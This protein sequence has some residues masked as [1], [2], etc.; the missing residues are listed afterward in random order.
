MARFPV[1]E[2]GDGLEGLNDVPVAPVAA[3]RGVRPA[4]FPV[5]SPE[6][7]AAA[8]GRSL[9]VLKTEQ[10]ANPADPALEREIQRT[11]KLAGTPADK[12]APTWNEVLKMPEMQGLEHE[13]LEEARNQ[14]FLEVV[15]P[16][17]PTPDLKAAREAFDRDTAPSAINRALRSLDEA[18]RSPAD[19]ARRGIQA[20]DV[21]LTRERP[22]TPPPEMKPLDRPFMERVQGYMKQGLDSA[23]ADARV[24]RDIEAGKDDSQPVT[25]K[26]G[27]AGK[28]ARE[29]ERGFLGMKNSVDG[30]VM[31]ELAEVLE[32][33]RRD[34]TP[35][36]LAAD[37]DYAD[38]VQAFQRRADAMVQRKR[39][40]DALPRTSAVRKMFE[41]EGLEGVEN[42]VKGFRDD[43][44]GATAAIVG[45]SVP[46]TLSVIAAAVLARLGGTGAAGAV[47]AGGTASALNEFG[48]DYQ[49]LREEGQGHEEAWNRAAIKSGVVGLFD[50]ASLASGGKALGEI[51]EKV[52]KAGVLK[53]GA[54]Q[55]VK[56]SGKQAAL[57]AGGEV[58]GEALSGREPQP[59]AVMAEAAGELI[60]GVGEAVPAARR[61]GEK[62][63]PAAEPVKTEEPVKA[64]DVLGAKP[65]DASVLG[66][67]GD[68]DLFSQP[69]QPAADATGG[70]AKEAEKPATAPAFVKGAETDF[71]TER[72]AKLKGQYAVIDASE[73]VTSHDDALRDNPAYPKELQPRDRK[74]D[75]SEM[76]IAKIAQNL[77]P[78]FLGES[79]Q[80]SQGAP[81]VGDD[82]V[83]ESGNARMIAL[84]RAYAADDAPGYR[85]WLK[86][87]AWKFGLKTDEIAG[88]KQ[89]VLVRLRTTDVNRAEF[90]RQANESSVAAMSPLEQA[91][92]DA[93]RIKHLDDLVT[94]EDGELST[95]ENRAFVR[96]FVGMLPVT[97][98]A[99]LVT[100][101]GQLSQS[102]LARVRN[103]ILSRAYGGGPV[104]QRLVESPDENIRAI[105]GGLVRA[106]PRVAKA[107]EA[108]KEG[109][110]HDLDITADLVKAVDWI[111]QLRTRGTPVETWLSQ[112][113]FFEPEA[114]PEFKELM[115]WLDQNGRGR[116]AKRVGEFIEAYLEAVQAAGS[117]AQ[118]TMFA[119]AVPSKGAIIEQAKKGIRGEEPQAGAERAAETR[120]DQRRSEAPGAEGTGRAAPQGESKPRDP[121]RAEGG[122]EKAPVAK[123]RP[124]ARGIKAEPAK[125]PIRQPVEAAKTEKRQPEAAP[126]SDEE[127]AK[128]DLKAALG[129]LGDILGKGTR[130][131]I[132]PEQEQKLLP[133]MTRLFDAAFRLGHIKFKQAARF[134]RD[135][136]RKALGK[137]VEDLAT[138]KRLKGAYIAMSD[139][140]DGADSEADVVAFTSIEELL[141]AS[142]AG[143]TAGSPKVRAD[144]LVADAKSVSDLLASHP[145]VEKSLG[146][147]NVDARRVMVDG[148]LRILED[149]K[150]FEAVVPLLPVNV[151][152]D[153]TGKK[154]TAEVLLGDKAVLVD[155]LAVAANGSVAIRAFDSLLTTVRRAEDSL[156]DVGERPS[157]QRAADGTGDGVRP[158]GQSDGD[159]SRRAVPAGSLPGIAGVREQGAAADGAVRHEVHDTRPAGKRKKSE[160]RRAS[161]AKADRLAAVR[162]HFT[163]GNI[164][165]SGYWR[166]HDRVLAFEEFE[167]AGW[168]VQVEKVKK[169][170]DKWVATGKPRW[171]STAP[172][173]RDKVVE[174]APAKAEPSPVDE[175][176]HEAASSPLNDKSEPSR[177]QIEANNAELGH[178]RV[179]GMDVSIENPVGSV[180]EDKKNTPPRWRV[181]MKDHYGYI[182]GTVAYDATE[183]R[184]QGVDIFLKPGTPE[185]WDGTVFVVNQNKG[186]GHF[187]EH[188]AM[189]G[190]DSLEEA[191]EAYLR[192]YDDRAL[193][194]KR[195]RSVVPAEMDAFKAWVYDKTEKG[196][197]GGAFEPA[198]PDRLEAESE[199]VDDAAGAGDNLEQ[200]RAPLPDEVGQG[201]L[202]DEPGGA[203]QGAGRAGA[204]IGEARD[205][206]TGDSGVP[207]DG[208]APRGE[209]GDQQ[210]HRPDGEYGAAEGAAGTDDGE[211]GG[212]AVG[213][214]VESEPAGSQ[215]AEEAADTA[216][217]LEVKRQK[218]RGAQNLAVEPGH[219]ANITRSLP[220]LLEGQQDD[221]KFAEDR[222]AKP[223]GHGVLFTNGTGTGKTF[224]GLGVVKRFERQGK[225]NILI[226]APTD[227]VLNAWVE[228]GKELLLD[229]NLLPD[230]QSAGDGIVATT[231]ANFGENDALALRDW[232]LIVGDEAHYLSSN[233]D[234][235]E[236]N[237]LRKLRALTKHARGFFPWFSSVERDVHNAIDAAR[238]A[239]D[240]PAE[241][242]ALEAYTAA[243]KKRQAEWDAKPRK[244]KLLALSATP[245]AYVK[246]VDWAEGYLFEYG[247][248]P[249]GRGYNTP[250]AQGAFFVQHFGFRMRTGKL[251]Q[252][253]AEVDTGLLEI[254]FN[255]WLKKQG[256]LSSRLL[257]VDKDY[258][259]SFVLVDAGIGRVIDEGMNW[260][261]EAEGGRFRPLYD[262]ARKRFKYLDRAFLLEA[263]KARAAVERAQQHLDLGRKVVVFHDYNKGGGFHPFHFA[264]G[265]ADQE[266]TIR[267][268]PEV[269]TAKRN[270][271]VAE[272]K[273]KR[274]DLAESNFAALNPP[275]VAF[276]K[277]FP[278]ALF[279]N[280]RMS[281]KE[282]R[283]ARDAFQR[284]DSGKNLI[285]VQS[286]AG[287]EGV[288]LHDVT[289]KHQR[290]LINL[291]LPV[292]PTAAIQIEGRTYR[293]G[294]Q[295]DAIFEYLNTGTSF[296]RYT[297]ASR[298]SERASTAE[299]L[300]LGAEARALKEA[301]IE[302][303]EEASTGPATAD[304]G[305]GGKER[306]RA[307][308]RLVSEF[309]KAKTYYWANQKKT[310]R[311]KAAEGVDYFATP[312]PLA[313]KMV[314]WA[315]IRPGDELLEPSAGHGAIARFFPK[316][317]KAKM[318]EPSAEL[319]TRAML[320]SGAELVQSR[321]EDF[322]IVNKADV[323]VMNPPFGQGGKTAID[324]LVKAMGHVRDGGRIVALLPRGTMAD[325]RLEQ[326]LHP[327]GEEERKESPARDFYTAADIELPSV[328]FER[329]G[330]SVRGHV[331][332]LDRV[333]DPEKAANM[334]SRDYSDAESIK[335]FFDRIENGS[336]P[337]RPA[338][339]E[340]A[341]MAST[342]AASGAAAASVEAGDWKL[343]E[344]K[345]EKGNVWQVAVPKEHLGDSWK[346]VLATAK[347]SDGWY[348]R[349]WRGFAFKTI[350][351][352]QAFIDKV[353]PKPK[354]KRE[355]RARRVVAPGMDAGAVQRIAAP[356]IGTVRGVELKIVSSPSEIPFEAPDDTQGVYWDGKLWLV[357]GELRTPQEVQWV[358]AH[359]L[360]HFGWQTKYGNRLGRVLRDLGKLN[361]QLAVEAKRLRDKFPEYDDV[362][363]LEEAVAD[364]MARG[365][366]SNLKGWDRFVAMVKI[367]L[368]EHGFT[369][370]FIDSL[371]DDE[372][373]LMVERV[374]KAMREGD[375]GRDI[376]QLSPAYHTAWHGSPHDFDEFDLEAVDS[377]EG[378]QS[379]GW[380]LY[381]T[382][383]KEVAEWYRGK[384]SSNSLEALSFS[385]DGRTIKGEALI[386][387]YF[388]PGRVVNG[389]SNKDKVI[390]FRPSTPE[391]GWAVRVVSVS[392]ASYV[393]GGDGKP[394]IGTEYKPIPYER[395]RWH[396]TWPGTDE[397]RKALTAEGWHERRG[398]LYKVDLAPKEDEY[399]DWNKPLKEQGASVQRAA[400][401][402]LG[403]WFTEK[404][405]PDRDDRV[406]MGS[407]FDDLNGSQI[408]MALSTSL[409]GQKEGFPDG[410]TGPD[411]EAASKALLAAGI[412]GIKYRGD[413][414]GVTN[415][416]IFDQKKIK[417]AAKFSRRGQADLNRPAAPAGV[418]PAAGRRESLLTTATRVPVQLLGIDKLTSWAYDTIIEKVGGI[419]PEK[420]KAGTVA[421]YGIPEAVIDRRE[422]MEAH[423]RTELRQ[424]QTV[425]D[426]LATLTR[427]E[428]RVAYAWMNDRDGDAL[429]AELP[430]E[431]Q[432][433]L[434]EVKVWI[435]ALSVEAVRLDQLS[436]ESY[437][438]NRMAYLHRS[439]R[440]YELDQTKQEQTARARSLKIRGDQYKG[441]GMV[442]DVDMKQV[443]NIAPD[444]W[445]RKLKEGAADKG[446]KGQKFIRFE[447]RENRGEGVATVPGVEASD[448]LGRL[449]D[450]VY[451][452][453]SEPVPARFGAWRRDA[454]EWEA[455]D[456]K[457]GKLIVWRDYTP[458]ERVKMGEIDEVRFAVAKTLQQMI[459]DVE[460][461]KFLEYLANTQGMPE[462]KLPRGSKVVEASESL[463]RSFGVDEWVQV[464]EGKVPGTAVKKYGKLAGLYIPGPIWNDV[465]QV[466]SPRFKPLGEAFDVAMRAW[467]ISKTALS[468]AVH[469][470]NIMA[471]VVMADWHDVLA[472][473]LVRA[474]AVLVRPDTPE[475]KKLLAAFEDNGG[476]QGMYTLSELQ[477]EQLSPLLEQ[478]E[479]EAQNAG[480]EGIINAGAVLQA[481]LSGQV[482]YAVAAAAGS[483]AA[484]LGK[485]AAEA[486]I[487][488][489]QAEDTVFRMAAFLKA[490]AE[491]KS[492]IEAGK[493]ARRSFLD[494]RINAP[495]IQ[496]LRSTIFPFIAF[497]YRALP[498]FLETMARK[499]W[500]MLK[501]WGVLAGLNAIGYAMSGGDEDKER[502][503]LPDEK[504]GGI[505][506]TVPK[507]IRMPWNDRDGNP[508]FL[509]IRRFVPVGDVFDLGQTHA[510]LPWSPVTVP[511]GPLAVVAE[512]LFN[513]SQFT[514]REI[515]KETDTALEAAGKILD[516]LYKAVA[517]NLPMLPGTYSF[518][519]IY[520]SAR[521]RTDVFG[522]EQ[523]TPAAVAS[524][525]GVKLG[526]YPA[527]VAKRNIKLERDMQVREIGANINALKR[528]RM[529]K[530]I[531]REEFERKREEQAEKRRQIDDEARDRLR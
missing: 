352:R 2:L 163:P 210:V 146:A 105:A 399:L 194:E 127:K 251:T 72:G 103:A 28:F 121:A 437:E 408:Y 11:A 434:R 514:G 154:G 169:D 157:N 106:A 415:Y 280:G 257:D 315:N 379:F 360:G 331:I 286:D 8:A 73:L 71:A 216:K 29:L 516:H 354:F 224:T 497:T 21:A 433:A 237:A 387:E 238:A 282:R 473:D 63:A 149:R 137:D 252:P 243:L 368:I 83:V 364:R 76:Q 365:E 455:R 388:K 144:S 235:V 385:K 142:H 226:V 470:N 502:K 414:S 18:V 195:V 20:I 339:P 302:A 159:A 249:E 300:A 320:A 363:S 522:R 296:E 310:S 253:E 458:E 48:N 449:L 221:V 134:V 91:K 528:E 4:G 39:Q 389:Y 527:D 259:R 95:A 223:D 92:S 84:R 265:A 450:L 234:G 293:I 49:A 421:D 104:L 168:Q 309:E 182:R 12:K 489:Y 22:A 431:S 128:A 486:M 330:T 313:F 42:F 477:R 519:S 432:A 277:A 246:S 479:R 520:D 183:K 425:L 25:V 467:K 50:A 351:A 336:V 483:K 78:E 202:F 505:W 228:S 463:W 66:G 122:D 140:K 374:A 391:R 211:R 316:L 269:V 9:S 324:H 487:D 328:T 56:E 429:L 186:N 44:A 448:Q 184:W 371:T 174:R 274:A 54:K 199:A 506:G 117:P 7:A 141:G 494:Y 130:L 152:N 307:T 338:K 531:S 13:Q 192:N 266:V 484:Q 511:G 123:K 264:E 96:R 218:Q 115:R 222:F 454:G 292:K 376:V 245:F 475:H 396:A 347:A 294:Q 384:L 136:I 366:A 499:P 382:S 443:Q 332:V 129:D 481:A 139:G 30:L 381:F 524:A 413:S 208:A 173:A 35:E 14:Y 258:E 254:Q 446:L 459:H 426:K 268:Y 393:P 503:L 480:A 423:M 353:S 197:K 299:N 52:T 99:A 427:A 270:E 118:E 80:A 59:G 297:F 233:A 196:P 41:G 513:K 193:A 298:I 165:Y 369:R 242:Q 1:G 361:P 162:E 67:G 312:E 326:L 468:P 161:P 247:R 32:A 236:T 187:D 322:H 36:E 108:M 261:N 342:A 416:V 64:D 420:V 88:V 445:G 372:V 120:V 456:T 79:P 179:A 207:P 263:I 65:K 344:K 377:G 132:T 27:Q 51:V 356:I 441:R 386:A 170:G 61:P 401:D 319:G 495:W 240:G 89:P 306:D 523:S 474:I 87:N 229:I 70:G 508:V 158:H 172:D 215:P 407:G 419:L 55:F 34:K 530:G 301:F 213:E 43:P 90:A 490:K 462:E 493:F 492:D 212:A 525:F 504:R 24:R 334:V 177:E 190:Y 133:V 305:K 521:G 256:V 107:R 255:E 436:T 26:S 378:A 373:T 311:T 150:I 444:W 452:P 113:S 3:R 287:R 110:L 19:M 5:E 451:W 471:N 206:R 509:D 295:S 217:N 518:K 60:M 395:P 402:V 69:P 392:R 276:G 227:N 178:P 68:N 112:I 6:E 303:F 362:T 191:R 317:H 111:A 214:G 350:E 109:A 397:V 343:V 156:A 38:T 131:N 526:S 232:D 403:E 33:K 58:Y 147:L 209:R 231:Y 198:P 404:G 86:T 180:R 119:D 171:H 279:I 151:V 57:G 400:R 461:G 417:V 77:Q 325:R 349:A 85:E 101:D 46:G 205:P 340:P 398:R 262:E 507:L 345:T 176:A 239:K 447:R 337:D 181:E 75:A 40:M 284:D 126:Q 485:R 153:L 291:G 93:D 390:E 62:P 244:A 453:A 409:G 124:A 478:L 185:D 288:S 94:G 418:Q 81:I 406:P 143:V 100:A 357:A 241:K 250:D 230:T 175:A 435:N 380:G 200:D 167:K 37:P 148:V 102:G 289:G 472:R 375:R 323:V 367:W 160:Q 17:V 438:R 201:A 348:A 500:K 529:R 321:F 23:A 510:V 283:A 273:R 116:N 97:E 285:V 512:L 333:S 411:P 145:A 164:V 410:F 219:R 278:G 476:T 517:P 422:R 272:F 304:Q 220:F 460:V 203:D 501:L 275:L 188:K 10:T 31:S 515:T 166:E 370:P 138:L 496:M 464:P 267:S 488:L 394:V 45:G 465:R 260:L 482:R 439:Y 308:R 318:I 430:P 442:D 457:G 248:E 358:A 469:M 440:K 498:M 405:S 346:D 424:A 271:L 53:A 125:K 466:A 155:K 15:A 359:E 383:Q 355:G 74:R 16:Q 491:G 314:E 281:K 428:S 329:A 135:E 98:Q 341:P 204:L 82:G 327:I 114:S 47:V 290:V 412:P 189:A 335:D 225:T